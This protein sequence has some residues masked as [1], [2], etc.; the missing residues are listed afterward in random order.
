MFHQQTC[1]ARFCSHDMGNVPSAE[2]LANMQKQTA[3]Y[4][5][6]HA[7]GQLKVTNSPITQSQSTWREPMHSQK[8][9]KKAPGLRGMSTCDVL[10]V[11]C[12]SAISSH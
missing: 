9:Q 5:F 7:L 2:R 1:S 4:T 6:L 12:Q 10:S 11:R 3:I 8:S